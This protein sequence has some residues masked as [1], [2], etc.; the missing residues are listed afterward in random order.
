MRILVLKEIKRQAF[1]NLP[2]RRFYKERSRDGCSSF[3]TRFFDKKPLLPAKLAQNELFS[4]AFASCMVKMS[5][6]FQRFVLKVVVCTIR[7]A[8]EIV[9]FYGVL[10]CFL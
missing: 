2:L 1:T 6:G 4:F 8:Y 10:C 7:L 9:L 5:G 3:L